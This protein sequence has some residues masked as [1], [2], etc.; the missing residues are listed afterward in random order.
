MKTILIACLTI[1]SIAEGAQAQVLDP[2]SLRDYRLKQERILKDG[3]R[4]SQDERRLQ[5]LQRN[6]MQA[7]RRKQIIHGPTA[8]SR[9]VQ[10]SGRRNSVVLTEQ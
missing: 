2:G 7:E 10:P 1:L 5:E 9:P 4:G 8:T 6:R 3:Q